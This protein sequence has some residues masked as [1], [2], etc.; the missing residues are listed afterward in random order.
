MLYQNLELY[1]VAEMLPA[2]DG[3]GWRLSRLPDSLRRVVNP[4]AAAVAFHAAGCELRL[5]LKSGASI[6]LTLQMDSTKFG[7]E[8]GGLVEVFQG[9]FQT[10]WYFIGQDPV[11]I[12]ITPHANQ[13]V[14]ETIARKEGMAFDPALTRIVLPYRPALRLLSLEGDGWTPPAPAQVP[15]RR[16]VIYG[17][18][19]THGA[20]SVRPT[21]TYAMRLAR[22]LGMDL[23]NLGFGGAAHYEP[24]IAEHIAGRADWDI[25]LLESHNLGGSVTPAVFRERVRTFA[26][27]LAGAHPKKKIYCTDLFMLSRLHPGTSS[28]DA[29]RRALESAMRKAVKDLDNP[30]VIFIPA[31]AVFKDPSGLTADMLHPAP[32]GMEEIARNLARRLAKAEK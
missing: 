17:T 10:S 22:N 5:N 12:V 11:E 3:N 16:L 26:G 7:W 15:G 13:A 31:T 28:S 18:S 30:N 23:I 4:A 6:R 9:L 27:I 14:L 24:A 32:T 29:V 21:E 25:A 19:L 20:W 1:N 8:R 2:E